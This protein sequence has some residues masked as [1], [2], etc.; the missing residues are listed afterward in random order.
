M[1]DQPLANWGWEDDSYQV[2]RNQQAGK[3]MSNNARNVSEIVKG[4]KGS[5]V[6]AGNAKS[7]SNH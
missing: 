4:R 3:K 7:H 5:G 6:T 1:D 2:T